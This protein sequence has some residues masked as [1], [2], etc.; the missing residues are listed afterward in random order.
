M[1]KQLARLL[2]HSS[3]HVPLPLLKQI[4]GLFLPGSVA[5]GGPVTDMVWQSMPSFMLLVS[6]PAAGN[7]W[8]LHRHRNQQVC[9][10]GAK[11]TSRQLQEALVS[12]HGEQIYKEAVSFVVNTNLNSDH[13]LCTT[14]PVFVSIVS[15]TVPDKYE[16]TGN[17]V[18]YTK[19][20]VLFYFF[21]QPLSRRQRIRRILPV[22]ALLI[23]A[24]YESPLTF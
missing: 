20:Y 23:T 13:I 9:P 18:V 7:I 2:I 24:A 17:F 3:G 12:L 5:S 16:T 19:G 11:H 4:S 1:V 8:H 10:A 14:D 21:D 22:L 6:A 15:L